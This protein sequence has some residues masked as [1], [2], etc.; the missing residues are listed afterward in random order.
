MGGT[1]QHLAAEFR[2][3]KR[4]AER[5]LDQVGEAEL[6][7]RTGT[8]DN[9]LA[10]LVQHLAG[11][12]ESRWTRVFESDGEKADRKRDAEFEPALSSRTEVLRR[13]EEGW[14]YLFDF[15]AGIQEEDLDREI[16]VRGERVPLGAS[17]V[18][19]LGHYS[20]H[21][22]QMVLLA[23]SRRG[24]DWVSLTIPRGQSARYLG[25]SPGAGTAGLPDDLS[26]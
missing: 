2:Y 22:G 5:A 1:L 4:V 20:Y 6:F 11:N 21:V 8:E 13:W 9:S 23:K 25:G 26:R 7:A 18:R 15:L 10:V 17:L 3:Q 19:Q 14:Q 12:M 24:P 16:L